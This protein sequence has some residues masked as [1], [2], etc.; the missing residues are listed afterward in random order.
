MRLPLLATALVLAV[1]A[2]AHGA[3][4]TTHAYMD[5]AAVAFVSDP[6]LAALLE[7]N[8]DALL[9]GGAFPDGGYASSGFPGGN[10][11]EDSHWQRFVDAYVRQI[12]SRGDCGELTDPAGPCAKVVAHLFG[13]AGPG[14]GDELWDWLFEPAMA[15]HGESPTHPVFRHDLPGFAELSGT[16]PLNLIN[17]SEYVMDIIALVDGGR[18]A[19]AGT[20]PP[21][22]DDLLAA[23]RAIRRDDITAPGLFAGHGLITAA[24]IGERSG[25][26]EEYARV[27]LTMPWSSAHMFSA[28]GGVYFNA[29]AIAAYYDAIWHT[30]LT[31]QPAPL[32]VGNVTPVHGS[33]GVTTDFQPAQ[34]AP[35]PR[36]GGS[37]KRIL[38]TFSAAIDPLTVTP[39]TFRLYDE[40][41]AAVAPMD[42][43]PRMGPYGPGDGE[44]TM[45]FY[46]A[47]DLAPCAHYTAEVTRG[48]RDWFGQRLKHPLRWA[49]ATAC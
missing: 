24:Q 3:G 28:P 14:L 46:P 12:R 49:F 16:T 4:V 2:P 43:W 9:S 25:L 45:M 7:A 5:E 44:H 29:R 38:A 11:G 31:G 13:A 47:E 39:E 27:K 37:A 30:L 36:G 33:V 10:Y 17:T 41:G 23:Y 18:L 42:G 48:V 40:A 20:F 21:P 15:D 26:A 34:T 35:G 32:R 8:G 1:A 22:S 19:K 6:K